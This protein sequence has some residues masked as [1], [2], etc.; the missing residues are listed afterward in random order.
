MKERIICLLYFKRHF[1]KIFLL[2]NSNIRTLGLFI[3]NENRKDL[4]LQWTA[5]E[6]FPHH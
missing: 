5:T 4:H 2:Q 1:I 3:L 6:D